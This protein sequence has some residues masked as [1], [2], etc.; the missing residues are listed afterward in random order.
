MERCFIHALRVFAIALVLMGAVAPVVIGAQES[1]SPAITDDPVFEYRLGSDLE[2]RYR[3]ADFSIENSV[4]KN[5]ID[6]TRDFLDRP[7]LLGV[8]MSFGYPEGLKAEVG[9]A[10]RRQWSLE[11]G[12]SDTN[13]FPVGVANNPIAIENGFVEL[14]SLSWNAPG[15]SL[16]LG[17]Q[18]VDYSDGLKGALLPSLRIPY[19]DSFKFHGDIGPLGIDWLLSTIRAVPAVDGVDVKPNGVDELTAAPGET[20]YYGFENGSAWAG[21]TDRLGN[22]TTIMEALHRFTWDFGGVELGASAHVMYARRNNRFGI[23]DILP[24]VSWHQ[25]VLAQINMSMLLDA[26]WDI[27]PSLWLAAQAGFDDFNANMVGINDNDASTIG[28]AVLG[29]GYSAET[30]SGTFKLYAEAGLTHF[31]WGN[32]DGTQ[33]PPKDIN[34]FLRFIYRYVVDGGSVL[35]PLTSPYGPG[36]LWFESSG[37]WMAGN[38]GFGVG[39]EVLLLSRN[40]AANLIDTPYYGDLSAVAGADQVLFASLAVPVRW[41]KGIVECSLT[42]ELSVK[43]GEVGFLVSAGAGIRLGTK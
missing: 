31:L 7:P 26:R 10:I 41:R 14:G 18:K 33:N 22:P 32:Y 15:L 25:A 4:Q 9:M 30:P 6:F 35:I 39:Y 2:Y 5:G 42:P 23:I 19:L 24:V 17:R 12:F 20:Y 21:D 37:E 1:A 43:D 11:R 3:T 13:L 38:T 34:P 8:Y 16:S 36:A 29:G 27:S 28:A 40:T